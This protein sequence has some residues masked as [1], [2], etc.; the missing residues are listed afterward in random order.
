MILTS[1][2]KYYDRLVENP[3]PNNGLPRVP[4]YGFSE[5]RISYI[6]LLN[7]NGQLVDIQH[8]FSVDT[9][10]KGKYLTVPWSFKRSGKFTEKAFKEGKNNAFFL[11][12]KTAYCLGI[13]SSDKNNWKTSQ[14]TFEAFKKLH[15]DLLAQTLDEGL[16][17]VRRF[18]ESWSPEQF[19]SDKFKPE[20][21]DANFAF[22]L[23]GHMGYV[24][25]RQEAID[26][27]LKK[28][29]LP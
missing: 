13:E 12:D 16:L 18:L 10:Q 20:M 17:A 2:A 28:L 4:D 6:L 19:N 9:K 22:R 14:L 27:W 7:S 5:E 11:W 29:L 8:N 3:N 1:L 26:I 15:V 24:H 25:E 21:A 23:D